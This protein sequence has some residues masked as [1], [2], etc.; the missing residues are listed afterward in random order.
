MSS[1]FIAAESVAKGHPD[2]IADQ[3]SDAVVDAYLKEDRNSLVGCETLVTKDG[4]FIGGEVCSEANPKLEAIIRDELKIHLPIHIHLNHQPK[5]FKEALERGANDQVVVYGYACQETKELMPLPITIA[6]D[7]IKKLEDIGLGPDGKSLAVVEYEGLWPKRLET[8]LVSM[9]HPH[10]MSL[11]TLREKVSSLMLNIPFIDEGTRLYINPFGPFTEGGP[12]LDTG[13]TGRKIVADSYGPSIPVGGGSFSGKDGTKIDRSGAYMARHI[14]KT[15]VH[16]RVADKLLV[17]LSYGIAMPDPLSIHIDTY[18]T[19]S[20]PHEAI[21][22]HIKERFP[23]KPKDI[24]DKLQLR[25]PIFLKTA[26]EGH[27][28]KSG[29]TWEKC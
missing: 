7:V 24:I 3:I 28:G 25:E 29:F 4:V 9:Q 18:G 21:I 17:G 2:K 27:F 11:E 15:L 23:L 10:E 22:A 1:I 14:A 6:R 13:V 26:R 19:S 12:L 5:Q 8:L 16:E 20:W